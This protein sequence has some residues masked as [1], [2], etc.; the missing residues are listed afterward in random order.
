MKIASVEK[1]GSE[2]TKETQ[3]TYQCLGDRMEDAVFAIVV[4]SPVVHRTKTMGIALRH[5]LL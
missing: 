3:E 4:F 2:M 1:L 5:S